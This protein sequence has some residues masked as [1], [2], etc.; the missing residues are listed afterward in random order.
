MFFLFFVVFFGQWLEQFGEGE[1]RKNL[2]PPRPPYT[3][4]IGES[5]LLCFAFK[6]CFFFFFWNAKKRDS[7]WH[8]DGQKV[9]R[10]ILVR[11]VRKGPP[12]I[13]FD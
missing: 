10:Q 4:A 13:I 11:R 12:Y 7:P 1:R 5:F 3:Y 9:L 8:A 6:V 2:P